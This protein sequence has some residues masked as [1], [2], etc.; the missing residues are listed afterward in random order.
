MKRVLAIVVVSVVARAASA[1]QPTPQEVLATID[2]VPTQ[3]QI[4]TAYQAQGSDPM[5]GLTALAATGSD[6]GERLR[7]IHA[8]VYYCPR[9][10]PTDPSCDPNTTPDSA[11]HQTLLGIASANAMA[12]SGPDL[13]VLRASLESLGIMRVSTDEPLLASFLNHN[14]RDV[15]AAAARALGDLCNTNAIV[16]LRARTQ[17]E[18]VD[19]VKLAISSALRA[20]SSCNP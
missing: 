8:L 14:S 19:Q 4:N 11:P 6:V 17:F 18:T 9:V 20:L 10:N 16:D 12:Q 7:A 5:T 3:E 15:R 2:T 1:P 13:L